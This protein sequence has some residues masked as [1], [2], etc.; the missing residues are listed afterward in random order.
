VSL[1]VI[2]PGFIEFAR[3]KFLVA[4]IVL[5]G[6]LASAQSPFVFSCAEDEHIDSV[7]RDAIDGIA[8]K[9]VQAL[10]NSGANTAYDMLSADAQTNVTIEQ[11][12][13]Q[14]TA[15]TKYDPKNVVIRHTYYIQLKGESPGRVV[16]AKDLTRPDGWESLSAESIPEQ[17]HVVVSGD[18]INNQLALTLWLVPEQKF[19]KVQS[20][21][22]NIASLADLDS[23]QLWQLGRAQQA[24]GHNFNATLL[25]SAA[26]QAAQRGP[27]FQMSNQFL[28]IPPGCPFRQKLKGSLRSRG[29]IRR[30]N[31]RF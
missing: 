16:C 21:W 28:R 26:A 6:T 25:L 15:I 24:K 19:W 7:K 30:T 8:T 13:N 9:F 12:Q 14:A 31:T 4:I 3:A 20:F 23:T 10:L 5:V 17:A 2:R 22:L 11:L 18:A 27:N 1:S 29:T